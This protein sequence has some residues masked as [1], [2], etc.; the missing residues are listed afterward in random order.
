MD[1]LI[2]YYSYTNHTKMIAKK[3][4]EKLNCDLLEINPRKLY[5]ENY[6]QVVDE[7]EDNLQT[8]EKPEL[9]NINIDINNY[10]KIIVGTPVWW[11]TITPPIRTFLSDYDLSGKRVYLFA[12]NAGWIG[13]TFEEAKEICNGNL[14][15]TIN[16]KF[17]TNYSE[18]KLITSESEIDSWIEK[19]KND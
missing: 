8:K 13:D 7:T 12:T 6:Q 19:I 9:E 11:Y 15:S 10:N 2:V 17:S 14:I 5:S 3:I 1:T 16:I 18:N 4:K